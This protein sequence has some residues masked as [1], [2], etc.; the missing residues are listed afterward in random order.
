MYEPVPPPLEGEL[1]RLRA[2]EPADAATLNPMFIDP[3]VLAGVGSV[4]FGQPTAGFR[5][6]VEAGSDHRSMLALA[7]ETLDDRTPAGGC[8]LMGIEAPTRH[9]L[10]G[11][12][13]GK[14]YWSRGYATDATRTLCRFGFRYMNLHRIELNV[15]AWNAAAIRAYE[16]VGFR[17]EGTRR[18]DGFARGEFV[19]SDMMGL[20]HDELIEPNAERR[21]GRAGVSPT[22]RGAS[23]T[24]ASP[25]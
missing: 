9:A 25:R 6:F 14:P 18:E 13:I 4:H 24:P 10:L 15:F 19:D 1:V 8:A 7:I 23:S 2:Y 20:L 22:T 3:D 12:W 17:I 16:K 11:I 21:S 5:D